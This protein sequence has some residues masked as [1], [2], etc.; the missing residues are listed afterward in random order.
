MNMEPITSDKQYT[1]ALAR[2]EILLR[3]P[4]DNI[5]AMKELENLS[6]MVVD[7]EKRNQ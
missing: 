6:L 3:E 2:I 7:Y 5:P 1:D 4:E